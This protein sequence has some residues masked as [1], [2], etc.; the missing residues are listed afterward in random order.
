MLGKN[1]RDTVV[2]VP[3]PVKGAKINEYI[4]NMVRILQDKYSVIGDLAEL[5]DILQMLRTKAVFLNW[6][7]TGL[8]RKMKIQ[9]KLYKLLGAKV[10]WVF[11]NKYPHDTTQSNEIVGNMEWLARNCSVILIHSKSSRKYI[12]NAALNIKKAVYLPHILYNSQNDNMD[13]ECVRTKYG[14]L[15]EDFVFTIFGNIKP[16]K[17]IEQGIAAFQKLHLKNAK[18]LMA[19][20][21]ADGN[22]ARKIKDLCREDPNIVLDLQYLP[23]PILDSIIDI[24]DVIVMPYKDGSSMN[25]G[26]MIQAFSKG[27]TVIV[28]DICMAKDLASNRFFYLYRRSLEKVM[29]KAYE[30]GKEVNAQMGKMARDYM[31]KNNNREIVGN[32]IN[33]ILS[34]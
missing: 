16:Y 29:L 6:I 11:H 31:Y 30:N 24:S 26:V 10:I 12:P 22:Y 32:R 34:M 8:N 9:L 3:Y 28:P 14:I 4:S 1:R 7:E 2:Y 20:P 15:K 21:P 25:S 5:T 19:G 23:N 17:N 13:L 18:L 33:K 27:K